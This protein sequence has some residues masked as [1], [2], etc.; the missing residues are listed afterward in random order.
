[1]EH[2]KNYDLKSIKYFCEFDL[3]WKTEEWLG[4]VGCEHIYMISDLGRVK[5]LER[6]K[7]NSGKNPYLRK[8]M[9]LKQSTATGGYLVVSIMSPTGKK[10][11]KVHK[12]VSISFL[13]HVPCGMELVINH[14]NLIKYDNRKVNLEIVTSRENSNLLHLP[15]KS[16]YVGVTLNNSNN[17]WRS[18]IVINDKRKHLGYFHSELEAHKAYQTALKNL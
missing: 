9:I 13:G 10:T 12:L 8:T 7:L 1:M 11:A 3:I 15:S 16:K 5:S 2:Y 17:K 6:I 18:R 4:V 14:K